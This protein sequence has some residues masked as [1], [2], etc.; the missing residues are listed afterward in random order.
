VI[1]RLQLYFDAEKFMGAGVSDAAG[2]G[3]LTNGDVIREGAG[4]L[5]KR[6][7]VARLFARYVVPLSDELMPTERALR[8][9]G[10]G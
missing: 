9:G 3:G 5:P 1:G 4:N 10:L 8:Q 2:L 7:Y 6:F